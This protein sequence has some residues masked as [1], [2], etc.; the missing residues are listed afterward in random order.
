MRAN[1]QIPLGLTEQEL[2]DILTEELGLAFRTEGGVATIHGITH[3]IARVIELDHLRIADQ[4][5][6]AGVRL[7][8]AKPES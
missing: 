1:T 5:E 8:T 4:L 3:S 2:R 7:K 6:K